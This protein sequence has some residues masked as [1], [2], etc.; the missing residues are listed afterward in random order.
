MASTGRQSITSDMDE[1]KL[2][3]RI[4]VACD[5][6]ELRG[7]EKEKVESWVQDALI[8]YGLLKNVEMGMVEICGVKPDGTDV[9]FQLTEAGKEYAD[10]MM[11]K[12]K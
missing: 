4:R 3:E 7:E 1:E 9:L 2:R 5:K 10:K 12:K 11:K 8:Q 6:H